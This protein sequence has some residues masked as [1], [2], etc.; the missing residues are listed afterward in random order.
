MA[1]ISCLSKVVEAVILSRLKEEFFVLN[2]LQDELLV[3]REGLSMDFQL[4]SVTDAI[5]N[6]I[7]VGETIGG[8]GY[9]FRGPGAKDGFGGPHR[10]NILGQI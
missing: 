8:G 3:S 6:S 2:I 7:E 10:S 1:L 9:T 4:F 5:R